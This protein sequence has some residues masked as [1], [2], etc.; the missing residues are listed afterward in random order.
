MQPL[1][2]L[3]LLTLGSPV[4]A[5]GGRASCWGTGMSCQ[6]A[7]RAPQSGGRAFAVACSTQTGV[8]TQAGPVTC[9][10]DLG[11]LQQRRGP[12]AE[13]AGR[14]VHRGMLHG[15]WL[16]AVALAQLSGLLGGQTCGECPTLALEAHLD[17]QRRPDLRSPSPVLHAVPR[18]TRQ[19]GT[20]NSQAAYVASP[21]YGSSAW[22]E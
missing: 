17:H 3:L 13:L 21:I 18:Q 5:G 14:A 7:G 20:N 19:A 1:L 4:H 12:Q 9:P 16:C 2:L 8:T 11:Q 15:C 10:K 22:K 6:P